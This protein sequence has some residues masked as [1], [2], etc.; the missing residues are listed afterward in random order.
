M[1]HAASSFRSFQQVG[2]I[3]RIDFSRQSFSRGPRRPPLVIGG[4]TTQA[5]TLASLPTVAQPIEKN[6][7]AKPI[8]GWVKFC[9]HLASEC[10][11]DPAEPAVIELTQQTWNTIV[12]VNRRA[13]TRIK[14][15]TDKE[16]WGLVDR[17]EFPDDG[18]GDCED[19]QPSSARC[20]PIAAFR[21][22]PCA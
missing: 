22:V 17:W 15:L 2:S 19:F 11:F 6:G 10:A 18:K 1:R 5:Q 21:V 12:S 16:H 20:S 8:L 13:N 14:P 7:T 4:A 3:G 9:E